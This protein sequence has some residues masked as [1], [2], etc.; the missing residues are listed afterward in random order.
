MDEDAPG[1]Y[2]ALLGPDVEHRR[3]E[4]VPRKS[5]WPDEWPSSSRDEAVTHFETLAVRA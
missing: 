5:D 4:Y 3:T 2:W 1:A